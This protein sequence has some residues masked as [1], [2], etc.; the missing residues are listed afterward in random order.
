MPNTQAFEISHTCH[1]KCAILLEKVLFTIVF[2]ARKFNFIM[3]YRKL[4]RFLYKI[5]LN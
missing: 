5:G 2:I 1:Q 4:V 3:L